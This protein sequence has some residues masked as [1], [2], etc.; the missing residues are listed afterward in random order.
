[1]SVPI[2]RGGLAVPARLLAPVSCASVL[3]RRGRLAGETGSRKPATLAPE[4][5]GQGFL[6]EKKMRDLGAFALG[7]LCVLALSFPMGYMGPTG[8]YVLVVVGV[9][10]GIFYKQIWNFTLGRKFGRI[11]KKKKKEQ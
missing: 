5:W 1:M 6:K 3:A 2:R 9:V 10:W 11:E 7:V 8:T 4:I